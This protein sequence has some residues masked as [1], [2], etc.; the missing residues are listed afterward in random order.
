[1]E[2]FSLFFLLLHFFTTDGQG[3]VVQLHIDVLGLAPR[4]FRLDRDVALAFNHIHA[5]RPFTIAEKPPRKWK[6]RVK[7]AVE[8][9]VDFTSET[10]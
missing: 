6:I 1:M 10:D 2:I 9:V 8:Q 5:G 7:K 4:N 3:P